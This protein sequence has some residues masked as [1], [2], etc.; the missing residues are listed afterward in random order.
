MPS[1]VHLE[2]TAPHLM[3]RLSYRLLDGCVWFDSGLGLE[4]REPDEH[5]RFASDELEE[6]VS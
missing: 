1:K 2:P 4:N 5:P 6:F 3:E